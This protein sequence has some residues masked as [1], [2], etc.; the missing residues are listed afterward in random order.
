V[1]LL[2]AI[3]LSLICREI[4]TALVNGFH[5]L[6]ILDVDAPTLIG[7]PAPVLAAIA[8]VARSV[9]SQAA[10]VALFALAFSR[11]RRRWMV[12]LLALLAACAFVSEEVRTPGEFALEYAIAITGIACALAF[13]VW[14]ARGNYLAYFAV[15]TASAFHP[16]IAELIHS[17]NSGLVIQG[18]ILAAVLLV[19]L[20]WTLGPGLTRSARSP[21]AKVEQVA[22]P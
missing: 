7:L 6:A 4:T 2:M 14:F 1:L 17:P 5:T 15:L 19:I 18:W 3:G 22:A 13:C 21:A 20:S 16:A 11:L 12:G 8:G 10:L 9:L